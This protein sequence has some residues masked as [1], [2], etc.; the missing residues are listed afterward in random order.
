MLYT[1]QIK[2]PFNPL[3]SHNVVHNCDHATFN[4]EC[5]YDILQHSLR[6]CM[7]TKAS[8]K[9]QAIHQPT[10]STLE[11]FYDC[12]VIKKIYPICNNR[13]SFVSLAE[14]HSTYTHAVP[15]HNFG[16]VLN[17]RSR[18]NNWNTPSLKS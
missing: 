15:S 13:K 6:I 1:T 14:V 12:S 7:P 9:F 11:I 18:E 5:C 4:V 2:T 16:V 3:W 10:S 17:A 8:V